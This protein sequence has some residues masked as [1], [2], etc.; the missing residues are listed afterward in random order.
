MGKPTVS[1][2]DDQE[3]SREVDT[4]KGRFYPF[5]LVLGL[6]FGIPLGELLIGGTVGSAVGFV[7]GGGIGGALQSLVT[8]HRDGGR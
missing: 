6:A 4:T 1:E 2:K 3:K 7:V 8:S 5:L